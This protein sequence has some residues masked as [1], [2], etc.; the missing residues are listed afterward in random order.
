MAYLLVHTE[1]ASEP[2][3]YGMA[4][5]WISPHQAQASMMEEALGTLS[6]CMSSRPNWPYVLAQLYK[7]SNHTPLPKDKHLGILPQEKVE[8]SPCGQISQLKVCQLLSTGPQVIYLVG[9]NRSNQPVTIDLP[10]PLHSGS[11]ITIDEYPY[12]RID[13]PLP[14]SEEPDHTTPPLGRVHATLAA[15]TPKTPWKPRITLMVE[16]NHLL[17]WG[18][19]DDYNCESEHSTMGKEAAMEA[20]MPPPQKAE[21]PAPP[22]DTSS[23]AS[24]EEVETSLESNPINIY[25]TTATCSSHSDSPMV[26]LTELQEDANLAANYMLSVK[27]SLDLKRQWAI[28]EFEA[29]L[30]Q[31]EAKEAAANEKAKIIHSRKNLDAKV[32]CAKAFMEAKYNY[33][34]AIQEAMMI[35][36]NQLQELETAY[37]EALGENAAM[38]STQSAR[39]LREHVK[40]MHKLKEQALR[41]ENKSCHNFLSAC[42]GILYHA[43]Q[44]LKENLS[45]SYHVLLGQL[46]LS[47]RSVP[48]AGT[49]KAEEQPS[50]TASPRPE[51]KW[52]LQPKRQH[53]SP[54]PQGSTSMDETFSKAS[55]EGPSSSKRRETPDWFASLKPSYADAFSHDSDPMKEAR[56]HYFATHPCGWNHDSTDDLSD[57][58]RELAEGAGLLG[59]SI[60]EIQLS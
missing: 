43:P 22:L 6:T 53:P 59:K 40:H 54:D 14:T 49:P 37:S 51:P 10:E 45:T 19:V 38:M 57:I 11:S 13:I 27:R 21:V 41:E 4:L 3:S 16:V 31:Q 1:D 7:G 9:L 35:R 52:S 56:S 20:D 32:G 47:L 5:V 55:Q 29:S 48:F 42:Q 30:H 46:P 15:T 34:M 58:F 26:D 18:M 12:I 25:P 17:N 44:P 33:R 39:L 60:H 8:E 28:W 2:E 50:A 36:C 24:V 23:Q